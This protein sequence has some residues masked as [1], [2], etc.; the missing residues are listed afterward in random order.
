[1]IDCFL[2]FIVPGEPKEVKVEA[3][4]SSSLNIKWLSP[5][6]KN[7]LIRGY[8]IYVQEINNLGEA[9]GDPIRFDV[10]DG[11]AEEYNLTTLQPDTE[12]S[13][14]V[15]AVT[16]KGDGM[17]SKPIN[18]RTFGGVPSRPEISI[19]LIKDEPQMSVRV[20]W[21]KPNHT[22]GQ[23]LEYKLRYGRIDNTIR[24]EIIMPSSE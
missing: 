19:S 8:Q 3:L 24:D 5:E 7:G 21:N 10:A 22:Y 4:N 15:A 14:Q 23:L 12:Y 9:S 16:R 11:M 20:L 17:R 18:K 2:S 6:A 1:M 13:I